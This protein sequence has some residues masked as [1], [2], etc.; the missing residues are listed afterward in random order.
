MKVL[1]QYLA[2]GAAGFFG[3][4][5]RLLLT[6]LCIKLFGAGFPIGTMIINVA[7]SFA[8][9]WLTAAVAHGLPISRT[10]QLAI[11]V[12]FI[13]AFTTFSTLM[14]D[15]VLLGRDGRM[16]FAMLN[17]LASIVLGLLAVGAGIWVATR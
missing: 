7:G 8:L 14:N 11:G 17:L 4:M 9:G 15:T 5:A 16:E 6:E 3:A 2:V 10:T 12:G 13:G 1:A